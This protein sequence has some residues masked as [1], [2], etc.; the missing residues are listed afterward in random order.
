MT[1]LRAGD[2]DKFLSRPDPRRP[3]VLIY[4]P[5]TGLVSER[6]AA[7]VRA[8]SGD[9]GDP[10]SI[11]PLEGDAIVA[12]PGLLMDEARTFGLF[13]NRRVIRVRAG[14]KNL[15][16]AF[17]PLI[18]DPPQT[19]IVIEAGELRTTSPLR[20]LCE[21]SSTAAA[22]PCYVDG[23]RELSRLIERVLAD[24]GL[25]IEPDAR[26]ELIGLL[27]ADRLASRSEID[28]LALYAKGEGR[29]RLDDVRAVIADA[30]A[31]VLDDVVDSAAAGEPQAALAALRKAYAAGTSPAAVL[32]AAI[33]HVTTLH[34]LRLS[35]DRG[36]SPA[37]AVENA[38]PA[39]FFRRK[40]KA[41]RA[42]G[43][44][45]AASFAKEIVALSEAS[46]GARKNADLAD[47]IAER[48][49][50]R[51]AYGSRQTARRA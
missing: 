18:A 6:A 46:L 48:A 10:F 2:I 44:F 36:D 30:S 4:G 43:R 42:L 19:T 26:E 34:R 12:D 3:I 39:I 50:L 1:V 29:I 35:V 20:S 28:K 37:R 47:T 23:D 16:P 24:S 15:A 13:G 49:I 14:G 32:G 7:V 38:R 27:G 31:L 5:D 33:R 21:K 51:L 41:E 25:A 11:V 45:D 8:V 17:E 40:P 22:I 9:G